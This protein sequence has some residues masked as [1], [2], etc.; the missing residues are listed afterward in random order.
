[1]SLFSVVE[2]NVAFELLQLPKGNNGALKSKH[3][4]KTAFR[5]ILKALNEQDQH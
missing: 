4:T 2:G 5:G 3:H 1:M